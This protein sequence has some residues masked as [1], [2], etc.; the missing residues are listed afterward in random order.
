T[1]RT[2]VVQ[3]NETFTSIAAAVYGSS[4]YYPHLIRANPNIDPRKLRPGMTI[5]IPAVTDVRADNTATPAGSPAAPAAPANA[6]VD[7]KSQYKVQSGDSLY[8]IAVKLYGKPDLRQKIYDL[9][10]T[11]IGPD[12]NRLKLGMVLNLPEAP[13][14]SVR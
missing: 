3:P 4:A 10:K 9:N 8:T 12:M 6:S 7:P 14:A 1:G 2:H 13:T 5:N 11:A